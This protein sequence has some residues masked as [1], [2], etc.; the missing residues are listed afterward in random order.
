MDATEKVV[1][2]EKKYGSPKEAQKVM[3]VSG[4]CWWKWKN[5]RIKPSR[6]AE[7]FMDHLLN[8]PK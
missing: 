3:G 4:V 7:A 5:G 1:E 2:I 8:R 6:M